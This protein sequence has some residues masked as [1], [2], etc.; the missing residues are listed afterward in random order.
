M[1]LWSIKSGYTIRMWGVNQYWAHL[2]N[3]GSIIFLSMIITCF[4]EGYD[5]NTKELKMQAFVDFNLVKFQFSM[6]DIRATL[7]FPANGTPIIFWKGA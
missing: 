3:L 4:L 2:P 5:S 6:V 1:Q 7:H